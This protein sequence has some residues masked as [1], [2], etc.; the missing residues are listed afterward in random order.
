MKQ[1]DVKALLAKILETLKNANM[2]RYPV[3]G[4]LKL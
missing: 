2:T 3:G 4:C 1:L